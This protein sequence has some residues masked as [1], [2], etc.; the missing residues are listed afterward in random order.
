MDNQK[1][2]AAGKT[3]CCNKDK[4]SCCDKD[5]SKGGCC[6][7]WSSCSPCMVVALVLLAIIAAKVLFGG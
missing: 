4:T 6:S 1:D 3:G 2:A 5:G 7:K